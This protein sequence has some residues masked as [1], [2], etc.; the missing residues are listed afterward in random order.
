M[1]EFSAGMSWLNLG[2]D[3][4]V[5]N[6]FFKLHRTLPH[7][8]TISFNAT[9]VLLCRS[10]T[11]ESTKTDHRLNMQNVEVRAFTY[12]ITNFSTKDQLVCLS[13]LQLLH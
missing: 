1:L 10:P 9:L 13:L 6:G 7:A 12:L 4:L 5:L 8:A 2:L 11:H 3:V